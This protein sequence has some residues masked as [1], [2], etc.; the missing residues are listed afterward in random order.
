MKGFDLKRLHTASFIVAARNHCAFLSKLSRGGVEILGAFASGAEL[1]I[2]IP[3]AERRKFFAICENMC[4]NILWSSLKKGEKQPRGSVLPAGEG[5]PLYPLV[6]LFRRTG[7][8]IGAAAFV[9]LAVISGGFIAGVTLNGVPKTSVSGVCKTIE[10]CGAVRFARFSKIDTEEI[11]K[12]ITEQ[13]PGIAFATV[14]KKGNYLVVDALAAKE[15]ESDEEESDILSPCDGVIEKI[16]ALRGTPLAKEGDKVKVG[17]PLVG[18]YF[19]AADGFIKTSPIA[20]ITIKTTYTLSIKLS[21]K[22]EYHIA[23]AVAVAREKCPF[24]HVIG[25]NTETKETDGGYEI[26]VMLTCREYIG[27]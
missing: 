14:Y 23:A 11:A 27:G 9:V 3:F 20:E 22:D 8:I 26:T 13:N 25:Q 4:Y 7:L 24:S 18:G 19:L 10:E 5:G 17:T 16:T 12:K 2:T 6:S 1:K 21:G 15:R